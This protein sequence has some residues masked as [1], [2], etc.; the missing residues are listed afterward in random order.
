MELIIIRHGD[1]GSADPKEY[2]DD[3]LRPLTPQG[4]R[5]MVQVGRGLR[6]LGID[7]A[8]IFD[9]GFVRARQTAAAICKAYRM[10]PAEIQTMR[11]LEPGVDPAQ[12]AAKLRTVRG[13]KRFA[14]VGHEPHLSTLVGYLVAGD[15][16][17]RLDIKKGGV[18][19]LESEKWSVGAAT[20][21]A[22]L[23]PKVLRMIE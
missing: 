7:F 23:P 8:A 20:L 1:A 6:R 9:S 2:P 13:F 12:T 16:G 22:A 4:K 17:I 18:C 14:I 11:E 21:L 15:G 3:S 10:D 19:R 5:D